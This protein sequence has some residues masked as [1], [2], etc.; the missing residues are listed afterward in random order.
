M[1]SPGQIRMGVALNFNAQ[2]ITFQEAGMA[3]Q[4]GMLDGLITCPNYKAY[5]VPIGLL[6]HLDYC[7]WWPG[8]QT[9]GGCDIYNLDWWNQF[10]EAMQEDLAQG[11]REMDEWK[12][13]N[14]DW[15][16]RHEC[17]EIIKGEMQNTRLTIEEF[18]RWRE[19]CRE[20]IWNWWSK[21]VEGAAEAIVAAEA[22]TPDL[23]PFISCIDAYLGDSLIWP[24]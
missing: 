22:M 19:A 13:D 5:M 14:I 2:A 10:P 21:D 12:I 17:A 20:P 23:E 18:E 11:V 9:A 1:T 24:E 8:T 3:L 16:Y 4:T 15:I 7:L 6:D